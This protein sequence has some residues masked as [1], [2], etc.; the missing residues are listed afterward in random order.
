MHSSQAARHLQ[1]NLGNTKT[2]CGVYPL[3]PCCYTIVLFPYMMV[4]WHDRRSQLTR[5]R[6]DV[7]DPSFQHW[8]VSE[9]EI[10][11]RW[12]V[13]VL[14]LLSEPGGGDDNRVIPCD[15]AYLL[16]RFAAG[17]R[18][19]RIG[20]LKLAQ[21]GSFGCCANDPFPALLARA[22]EAVSIA[23]AAARVL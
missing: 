8:Q 22:E 13:G 12:R 11:E 7:G 9:E 1:V 21:L 6:N 16:A 4:S 19:P 17:I 18:S 10:D 14:D 23:N 20:K 3:L 5:R 2:E 15:D